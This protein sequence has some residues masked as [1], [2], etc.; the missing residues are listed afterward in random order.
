MPAKKMP[1]EPAKTAGPAG[2]AAPPSDLNQ[3]TAAEATLAIC[4]SVL[5]GIGE[6]DLDKPTPCSSFTVGEL[7]DHL[8]GSMVGLGGMAGAA[9]IPAESGTVE[10][11]VAFAAQQ[12]LDAWQGRGLEGTVKLGDSDMPAG[13]AASILSLELLIHA[14]DFAVATGQQ[15]NVSD[16]VAHY[17]LDLARQVIQPQGRQDGA[18]AAAIEVGPEADILDRL[19]AFSGRAV[20]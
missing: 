9:V 8:I 14:W 1:D 12:A 11:R 6:S 15:V 18:F 4:Q 20:T 5:R 19:I 17:V 3:L 13:G 7:A 2:R 10:S 16:Q